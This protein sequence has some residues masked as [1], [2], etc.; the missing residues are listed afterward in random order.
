MLDRCASSGAASRAAR[1]SPPRRDAWPPIDV[2]QLFE[3]V[4]AAAA[5]RRRHR[6]RCSPTLDRR[7]DAARRDRR[8]DG[9]HAAASAW[10]C[11]LGRRGAA[12]PA[13]AAASSSA[14][15]SSSRS[16]ARLGDAAARRV[17][18]LAAGRARARRRRSMRGGMSV[19]TTLLAPITQRSPIVTPL[20][21]TTLAPHQTL[22]P[23]R[24]GPL[25][26]KPCH[27]TGR[28]RVVEA[29]VAVGDEAAVGEHAVRA[30]LDELDRGDHHAEVEERALADAHA[31]VAGRGD[32]HAAARAASAAPISRRPSRSASRT[33]PCTGQRTNASRRASSQWMRARFQ[34]SVLRSYQ[35]HFCSHSLGLGGG[36]RG[37]RGE[38]ARARRADCRFTEH[39]AARRHGR[40]A[41][42][43]NAGMLARSLLA[44]DAA[45]LRPDPATSVAARPHRRPR[46]DAVGHR[47]GQRPRDERAGR[48]QR[49]VRPGVRRSPARAADPRAGQRAGAAA[50]GTAPPAPTA[51][52]G[53]RPPRAA[54]RDAV[55]H[56]RGQRPRPQR[57]RRRQ[58]PAARPRSSSPG[59]RLRIPAR[60]DRGA[61]PRRRRRPGAAPEPM[62]GYTVAPG[63]TLSGPGRA[64]RASRSR[65]WPT[66]NGLRPR[67][68]ADR[69]H[70][71]QAPDGRARLGA[72]RRPPRP[73]PPRRRRRRRPTPSPGR[74]SAAQVRRIAAQHGVP[75][76]LAAAI[77]WQESGFNNA[78]VSERQRA[79]RHAGHARHLGLGAVAT[80]PRGPLNPASADR[81][82]PRRL[83]LPRP[84]AA[85][86]RRRPG[87]AAAAYYQ[88]LSSV[89]RIGMLPE[90]RR[91]VA[92]VLALRGRFGG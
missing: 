16:S 49:P 14:W 42:V 72:R 33:L 1:R 57:A 8:R 66:M 38:I 85:R 28:S 68:A 22:S 65:R 7:R 62:G 79:R 90:T 74:L 25:V 37:C 88:G 92:N 39:R 77:A 87:A 12:V 51:P 45:V 70:A 64:Q 24:V 81:Q 48:R 80:S 27:V 76:S 61:G 54:R 86:H 19:V 10:R 29:V 31:R 9:R 44:A 52:A 60:A 18:D 58:R 43:G 17:L 89:R 6:R 67:R 36:H 55:R 15:R 41:V 26:V 75:G 4:W 13:C 20:V 40:P 3:L 35:R 69:R 56:R 84:A 59:T 5:R 11:V 46:R 53:R 2:G 34:G 63:D 78:M 32:P 47:R 73:A 71:A 50:A 82:R 91:Y 83:A 23:M 21:T 30:D